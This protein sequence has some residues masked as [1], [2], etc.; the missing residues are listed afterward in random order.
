MLKRLGFFTTE[1]A[2]W[3]RKA[4]EELLVNGYAAVANSGVKR[5]TLVIWFTMNLSIATE[6]VKFERLNERM[7]RRAKGLWEAG[8]TDSVKFAL[9]VCIAAWTP[10][11]RGRPGCVWKQ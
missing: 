1:S 8:R 4:A 3:S 7:T 6:S 10:S 11:G 2:I 5:V 9:A